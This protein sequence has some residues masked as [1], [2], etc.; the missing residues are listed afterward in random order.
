MVSGESR[1]AAKGRRPWLWVGAGAVALLAGA[2]VLW[3]S[4]N[5]SEDSVPDYAL[6][7]YD[8]I[9]HARVRFEGEWIPAWE[10]DGYAALG[11][12]YSN[13]NGNCYYHAGFIDR[14]SSFDEPYSFDPDNVDS[15]VE[16]LLGMLET[17]GILSRGEDFTF[18]FD[19]IEPI[20]FFT[21]TDVYPLKGSIG[22][23][24]GQDMFALNA[25]HYFGDSV[26][27]LSFTLACT[28]IQPQMADLQELMEQT[29][30]LVV[31]RI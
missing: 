6:D 9:E 8:E 26:R 18:E 22:E 27:G 20:E 3:G 13:P 23:S 31:P 19:D 15:S 7:S 29:N 16:N 1:S 17:D 10:G 2:G 30:V 5:V 14:V 25:R 11:E 28:E 12:R 4:S 21:Y 24:L